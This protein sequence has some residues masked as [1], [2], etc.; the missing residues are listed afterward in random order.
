VTD[1]EWAWDA[2]RGDFVEGSTAV[3][4]ALHGVFTEEPFFLDLRWARGS[5]H[6][7]LQHS[8]FRD[9]IAQL[10]APMHGVSTDELEGED[11][12]QHRRARRLQSGAV[13]TLV[14]LALLASLTGMSAVRNAERANAERAE[15]LRQGKVADSQRD[16]A[17]RSA[18]E[19]RRQ[20]ELARQQQDR[21]AQ[22]ATEAEKSEKLAREQQK[23]ADQAAAE[24]KRQQRLADQAATRT[25]E[26]QRLAREAAKR[27]EREQAE[28]KRLA[29]IAAEQK[30]LA[31][32][33]AKEA[34]LQQRIAAS[35]RL[36]I[37]ARAGIVDDPKTSLML[38]AAA[39]ELN[40]DLVTRR[41]LAG[42]V[43]M[44]NYA[45]SFTDV[46]SAKY[47][48]RGELV[49]LGTD[50]R[51][52]LWNV[53]NPARPVRLAT[54]DSNKAGPA[55][56]IS[57]DGRTL[58]IVDRNRKAVLWDIARPAHPARLA[59]LPTA[60]S[61]TA[62]EFGQ[63]GIT[64]ATG[65]AS[66]ATA[67]W[68]TADRTRPARLATVEYTDYLGPGDI[69]APVSALAISPNG[70]MLV[71]DNGR[72]ISGET[73]LHRERPVYD[74][75]DRANPVQMEIKDLST[76]GDFAFSPDGSK[77]A[78]TVSG[79]IFS[80]VTI[81]DVTPVP[82]GKAPRDLTPPSIPPYHPSPPPM[83]TFE[84]DPWDTDYQE[85]TERMNGLRGYANTLAFSSKGNLVAAADQF[86][87]A[88]VWDRTSVWDASQYYTKVQARHP[89]TAVSFDPD[90]RI[91]LTMDTSG[92]ARLWSLAP[93]GAPE[94]LDTLTGPVNIQR[95]VFS[96]DGRS[97]I[98]AASNGTARTWNI[99]SPRHPIRGADLTL[100]NEELRAV[101]FSPDRRTVVTVGSSSGKVTI[102]DASR[103][104]QRTLLTTLPW[105]W[106]EGLVFSPD[107]RTLLVH[108]DPLHVLM[109]DVSDRARPTYLGTM[110]GTDFAGTMTFSPDGRTLAMVT[111]DS[112]IT[113][114]NMA[115][116]SAPVR[117]ATMTGHMGD[118]GSLAFSPNGRYLVSGSDDKTAMLWDV[119]DR[120]RPYRIA[121]LDSS[122]RLNTVA[123]SPDGRTVA[124]G[125][126]LGAMNLWD[127]ANPAEPTRLATV[128][129][130]LDE[131]GVG[132][133]VFGRDGRTL[134]A[135]GANMSEPESI[136]LWDYQ[137]VN[138]LR[139]D[140]AKYACAVAGRGL[141]AAEWARLIPE[142]KYRR[143]CT[144]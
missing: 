136:M 44:T 47:G 130:T 108:P 87:T 15:A 3:P 113:L 38:G 66:G 92:T 79:R 33:A 50:G 11:V 73:R 114:W 34:D 102:A 103:P 31:G 126:Y 139:A 30:R 88:M 24:A 99:T 29:A 140:P 2:D 42:V 83:P 89:I 63:D 10:A 26:Q 121:I 19:A 135:I 16:I 22:A 143:T 82:L 84:P 68:D 74:I 36:M 14:V 80:T 39:E 142:V 13:A 62:L 115:N 123:V 49:T 17:E 21:A 32:E 141:T 117:I 70:R 144:G 28:A 6:L 7:S 37:K 35:R 81:F 125:D 71:V 67:L 95:T 75:A 91:L 78:V 56:E 134:A 133:V 4:P 93:P 104:A 53:T 116:R 27:A 96:L 9:A 107:G 55:P 48:P 90:A 110:T 46:V 8:R 109:W 60:V 119:T 18:E 40:P 45:G 69:P 118:V 64:F 59:T 25:K 98:A 94:P 85:P 72:I 5:E 137:K 106:G 61:I 43:P 111:T 132:G 100:H 20:G 127:T 112:R 65:E 101:A 54:F 23:V 138:Q 97:L 52:S 76:E 120:T 129:G 124:T 1:G 105:S 131:Y 86:G 12:R 122:D 77:L 58:A 41:Q 57:K 51:V 128:R